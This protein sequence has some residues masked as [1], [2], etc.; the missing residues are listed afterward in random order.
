MENSSAWRSRGL[1]YSCPRELQSPKNTLIFSS[2]GETG[3]IK[4]SIKTLKVFVA[5]DKILD[6]GLRGKGRLQCQITYSI[7]LWSLLFTLPDA[8]TC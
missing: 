7:L 2:N 5:N 4:L 1:I 3:Q 8:P 6:D